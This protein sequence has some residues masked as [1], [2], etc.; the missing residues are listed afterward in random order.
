MIKNA[1]EGVTKRTFTSSWKKRLPE[2]VVEC[3]I[4]ESETLPCGA[5]SQRDCAF[6]KIRRLEVDSNDIDD[7]V[8]EHSQEL[9]TEELMCIVFHRKK[10]RRRIC[11]RR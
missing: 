11:Q 4:G 6:A 7:L 5:Y 8:E 2:N 3:N 1:W 10:L 9:T